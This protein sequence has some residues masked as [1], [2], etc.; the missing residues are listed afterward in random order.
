MQ[1]K[2][3]DLRTALSQKVNQELDERTRLALEERER[4]FAKE[5]S[6][7]SDSQLLEYVRQCAEK[8]GHSPNAG[9]VIGGKMIA[10]RLGVNWTRVLLSA[11]LPPADPAKSQKKPLIYR[12]E[13]RRQVS[14]YHRKKAQ[15]AAEKQARR[16]KNDKGVPKGGGE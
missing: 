4:Q 13:Y 5:H 15:K 11:G 6:G 14:L 2:K 12:Q 10:K 16:Q 1:K 8:L 9:E 7:D 3:K